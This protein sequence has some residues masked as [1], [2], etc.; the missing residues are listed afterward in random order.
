[1][2]RAARALSLGLRRAS[3]STTERQL[4]DKNR[5]EGG[6]LLPGI[7]RADLGVGNVEQGI[8][9]H[10]ASSRTTKIRTV[11]LQIAYRCCRSILDPERDHPGWLRPVLDAEVPA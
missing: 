5:C 3:G 1:M 11:S 2:P 6:A 8:P 9:H 4:Q 7:E 10:C